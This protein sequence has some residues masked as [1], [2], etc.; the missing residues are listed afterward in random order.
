ML[1][2]GCCDNESSSSSITKVGET[3][4]PCTFWIRP[5]GGPRNT[6]SWTR[7]GQRAAIKTKK[8]WILDSFKSGTR[9]GV[10]GWRLQRSQ[11]FQRNEDALQ[12]MSELVCNIQLETTWRFLPIC[13]N[14]RFQT[15]S[16][17]LH[18]HSSKVPWYLLFT[19]HV[20]KWRNA[21]G[22]RDV[23]LLWPGGDVEPIKI[24]ADA[25]TIQLKC[26]Q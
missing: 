7:W 9:V 15:E 10:P 3:F 22:M 20:L 1:K 18:H 12:S 14:L 2:L 5:D 11:W 13:R 25:A 4:P 21:T 17:L 26:L 8:N 24:V 16:L 23:V 6:K 19:F